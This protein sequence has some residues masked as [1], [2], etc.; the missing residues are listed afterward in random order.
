MKLLELLKYFTSLLKFLIGTHEKLII[1]KMIS[2][3]LANCILFSEFAKNIRSLFSIFLF[4][5]VSLAKF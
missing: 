3:S 1:I 4:V 2:I 5:T